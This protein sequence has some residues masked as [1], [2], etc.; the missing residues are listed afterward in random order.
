MDLNFV[1]YSR[2]KILLFQQ[3]KSTLLPEIH[4]SSRPAASQTKMTKDKEDKR[5]K[6]AGWQA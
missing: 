3:L 4:N 5:A 6:H 1:S 2:Q